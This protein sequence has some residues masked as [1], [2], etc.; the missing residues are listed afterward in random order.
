MLK[1][2]KLKFYSSFV[3]SISYENGLSS[4]I[5]LSH[6]PKY[7]TE[8]P[9]KLYSGTFTKKVPLKIGTSVPLQYL[10]LFT[11]III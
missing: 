8:N 1:Q 6:G 5:L 2:I 9:I 10:K 7:N 3:G 11:T 4:Y